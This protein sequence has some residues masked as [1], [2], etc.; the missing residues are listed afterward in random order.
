MRRKL[1]KWSSQ[2]ADSKKI[3]I[4]ELQLRSN[5]SFKVAELRLRKYFLLVAELRLR[6]QKKV[7]RAHLCALVPCLRSTALIFIPAQPPDW[8][9]HPLFPHSSTH[10]NFTDNDDNHHQHVRFFFCFFCWAQELLLEHF[11]SLDLNLYTSTNGPKQIYT[12]S[13]PV[14]EI[15]FF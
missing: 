7:A 14:L 4:A 2:V 13:K 6:T 8:P 11:V 12:S 5:I 15:I 10:V 9:K 1:R 3:A